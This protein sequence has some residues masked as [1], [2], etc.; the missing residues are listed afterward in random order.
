MIIA[1]CGC[2]MQEEDVVEKIK[3]SYRFVDVIFGTHNI[4]KLAELYTSVW[5][6]KRWWLTSGREQTR[7]WK[8]FG[9]QKIFV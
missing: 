3:K 4:Y 2:M 6:P 9:R 7:W 1:L 8:I 5:K